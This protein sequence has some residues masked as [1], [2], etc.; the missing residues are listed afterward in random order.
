MFVHHAVVAAHLPAHAAVQVVVHPVVP[1]AVVAVRLMA[2]AVRPAAEVHL[3][4][5][6]HSAAAVAVHPVV[7]LVAVAVR[8][9]AVVVVYLAAAQRVILGTMCYCRN[10]I[11]AS[12]SQAGGCDE[13]R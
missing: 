8:L 9:V 6:D 11:A 7:R 5:P 3:A 12:S 1:L 10:D 4:V 13:D 2:V